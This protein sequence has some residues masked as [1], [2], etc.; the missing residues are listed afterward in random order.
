MD[1][2]LRATVTVPT[3]T[4]PHEWKGTQIGPQIRSGQFAWGKI[5]LPLP[6][7]EWNSFGCS[8]NSVLAVLT[9]PCQHLD[10]VKEN[11]TGRNV[12]TET[13]PEQGLRGGFTGR[14]NNL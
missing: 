1:G 9:T 8:T 6:G 2:H 10:T 7:I 14:R 4:A 12:G 11:K 13:S 5:L 3:R